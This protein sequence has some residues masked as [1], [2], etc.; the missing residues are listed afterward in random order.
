VADE[1]GLRE[2]PPLRCGW[3]RKGEQAAVVVSGRNARRTLH[4]ALNAA[5][6]E[7]VRTVTTTAKT[8]DVVA[9]VEALG[10]GRPRA[11]TLPT[12]DNAPPHQPKR[13]REAAALAG[14]EPAF[15]PSRAPGLM[16]SEDV[17][18][19]AKAGV[20]ANRCYATMEELVERA[21]GAPDALPPDDLLRRAGLRSSKFQWLPT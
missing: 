10:A 13:A 9:A 4:G 20:A 8:A 14:I 18:R 19:T 11:P 17:R 21:V 6:G 2:S 5:T 16:P 15:L 3:A 7:L 1:T 12:W